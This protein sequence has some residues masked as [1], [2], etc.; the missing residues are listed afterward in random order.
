MSQNSN[1]EKKIIQMMAYYEFYWSVKKYGWLLPHNLQGILT[2]NN[3]PETVIQFRKMMWQKRLPTDR[4]CAGTYS[5]TSIN[6]SRQAEPGQLICA[7]CQNAIT[8]FYC[9]GKYI[10]NDR[11]PMEY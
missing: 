7:A 6:C 11:L 9:G 8:H 10:G 3:L 5:G 4:H 1:G 2:P